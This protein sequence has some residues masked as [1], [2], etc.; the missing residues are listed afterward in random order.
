MLIPAVLGFVC[1]LCKVTG[2]AGLGVRL[3][4]KGGADVSNL[5]NLLQILLCKSCPPQALSSLT[6]KLSHFAEWLLH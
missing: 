3:S 5:L 1:H 4:G 6:A 2:L